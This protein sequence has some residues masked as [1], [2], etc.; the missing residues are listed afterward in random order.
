MSVFAGKWTLVGTVGLPR[1]GKSTWAHQCATRH[2][3]PVVSLD[4]VRM[5]VTGRIDQLLDEE[6]VWATAKQMIHSLFLAGHKIV[7]VD[8]FNNTLAQRAM[9]KSAYWE[10]IWK[11]FDTPIEVCLHRAEATKEEYLIPVI[12]CKAME[13]EKLTP[14]EIE[15]GGIYDAAGGVIRS[16]K[17]ERRIAEVRGGWPRSGNT[18]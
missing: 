8:E 11:V 9:W 15:C 4:A 1:S 18:L 10:T 6:K 2:G 3:L 7:I 13:F 16:W 17:P 14:E 5:A 12:L